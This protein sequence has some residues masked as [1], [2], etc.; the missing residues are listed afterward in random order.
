M[1]GACIAPARP[2][3]SHYAYFLPPPL[4]RNYLLFLLHHIPFSLFLE[5]ITLDTTWV[6]TEMAPPW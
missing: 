5:M 1:I 3:P 4:L 2:S 6:D